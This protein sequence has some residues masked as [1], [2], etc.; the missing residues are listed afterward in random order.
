MVSPTAHIPDPKQ[1][2][3]SIDF[4]LTI[5][6]G[7]HTKLVTVDKCD[8]DIRPALDPSLLAMICPHLNHSS[9]RIIQDVQ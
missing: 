1:G 7:P 3:V 5:D 9:G 6:F 2:S 4:H 8:R